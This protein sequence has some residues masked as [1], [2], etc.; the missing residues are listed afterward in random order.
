MIDIAGFQVGE[1]IYES[2]RSVVYRAS[3]IEGDLPVIVKT[4]K[5]EYPAPQEI[6][7]Y[8][9]EYETIRRLNVAGIPRPVTL[10]RIGNRLVLIT[11]DIGGQDLK[12]LLRNRTFTLRQLLEI[13]AETVRILGGLHA[14]S[15]I[16]G[17]IKPSNIVFNPQTN[18]LQIIDFG[19]SRT[20]SGAVSAGDIQVPAGT[21]PYMSPEQTGRMN[22]PVDWRTDFYSLGA[23]LYELFTGKLPFETTD[24][25]E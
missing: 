24:A 13:A 9:R 12:I 18:Q 17:D 25:L 21:L 6:L 15:L 7:R 19:S 22:R 16:H 4:L 11:E 8:R 2:V 23:T 3:Q 10:E 20:L 14:A 1:K 5:E